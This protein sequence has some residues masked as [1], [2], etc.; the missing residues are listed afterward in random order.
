MRPGFFR[1]GRSVRSVMLVVVVGMAA[2][3]GS[4]EPTSGTLTVEFDLDTSTNPIT[5]TFKVTEGADVLGCG[6]GTF[7]DSVGNEL[8]R[9]MTCTDG[10]TGTVNIRFNPFVGS[11]QNVPWEIVDAT[12]DFS[13]LEGGGDWQGTGGS[14]TIEGEVEFTS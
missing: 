6:E 8:T 10:G 9:I 7:R 5:G 3:C 13:G 2:A 12:D 4:S 1:I 11:G 14:E